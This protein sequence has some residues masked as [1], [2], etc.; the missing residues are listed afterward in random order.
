MILII[1][2]YLQSFTEVE[3]KKGLIKVIT[4]YKGYNNSERSKIQ[5]VDHQNYLFFI[6]ESNF[7]KAV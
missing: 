2:S 1:F 6:I 4:W 7:I 5:R 3:L